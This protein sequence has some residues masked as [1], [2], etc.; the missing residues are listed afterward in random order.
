MGN[1][2]VRAIKKTPRSMTRVNQMNESVELIRQKYLM[3]QET[4]FDKELGTV[5][6]E[7]RL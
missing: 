4:N 6:H 2:S 5:V 1:D 7:I 3:R